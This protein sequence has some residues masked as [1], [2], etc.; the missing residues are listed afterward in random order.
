MG[1]DPQEAGPKPP[2]PKQVQI[3]P[4]TVKKLNPPADHGEESYVGT[5]KL[6]GRP[7]IVTGPTP[8]LSERLRLL[9]QRRV[10]MCC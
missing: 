7:A 6:K 4:G 3:H 9:L 10:R 5:G 8:V 1:I 2:F